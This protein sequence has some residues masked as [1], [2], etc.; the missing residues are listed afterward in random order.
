L[1]INHRLS[2]P[3]PKHSD[4]T[5]MIVP[6][7]GSIR[8][9]TITPGLRN[10]L[11][12]FLLCLLL[13]AVGFGV[14]YTWAVTR[15]REVESLR[16]LTQ[17]QKQKIDQLSTELEGMRTDIERVRDLEER[18]RNMLQTERPVLEKNFRQSLDG[19]AGVLGQTTSPVALA[20]RGSDRSL[21][22]LG[23]TSLGA[24]VGTEPVDVMI[25]KDR[26][27]SDIGTL[28][29][30]MTSLQGNLQTKITDLR[31]LP[32][33]F[34]C[35][36]QITSLFGGRKSPT[37][38][39]GEFHPGVDIAAPYG[40]NIYAAGDGK[41]TSAGYKSGYGLVVTIAHINGIVT[42]YCHLSKM[43]VTAGETVQRGERIGRVGL[44][45]ITTGPHLHFEVTKAGQLVDP[46][47][48]LK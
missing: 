23:E 6:R 26:V 14:R 5:V 40:S 13:V 31:A 25:T 18:V 11:Q 7:S 46:M 12:G 8:S 1:S 17:D 34:P 21:R 27:A 10:K 32:S 24:T 42:S 15:A 22:I 9:F 39:G 36:G 47:T 35:N 45:G 41:V 19:P 37:G 3:A 2:K 20:S 16:A 4:L 48:Y 44:S 28:L 30:E 29:V 43:D 33:F 38:G